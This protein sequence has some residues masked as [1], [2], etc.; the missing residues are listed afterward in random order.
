MRECFDFFSCDK[1]WRHAYERVYEPAFEPIRNEPLRILDIGIFKGAS[2]EVWLE[3]FPNATIF[4]IDTFDRVWPCD[5]AIL[6]HPRVEW[7]Q[8]D[9]TTPADFGKFD[10][11][12]DDGLHTHKAQRKTLEC[13]APCADRYFIEDVWAFDHMTP[14]E[15]EHNWLRHDGYSEKEYQKLLNALEPYTVKFHD[16]RAG[17]QPDS[18]IIGV[19]R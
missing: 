16:M 8:H 12:I 6:K 11:A 10:I 14:K 15:K 4:G 17:H 3:Y 1:G 7:R 9:S 5:I 18:F 19:D 2:I 13:F